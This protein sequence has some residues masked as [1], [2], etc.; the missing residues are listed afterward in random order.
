MLNSHPQL[1]FRLGFSAESIV[2]SML[3]D[4]SGYLGKYLLFPNV[5]FLVLRILFSDSVI[6]AD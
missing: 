2:Q 3:D 6:Y 1:V 4:L 5:L